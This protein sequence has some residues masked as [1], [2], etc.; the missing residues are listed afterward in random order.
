MN[1]LREV[2]QFALDALHC[3][4]DSELMDRV[5]Q[6]LRAALAEPANIGCLG[7][8]VNVPVTAPQPA[9]P[10]GYKLVPVEPT[11]E[12]MNR[13]RGHLANRDLYAVWKTMAHTAPEAPQPAKRE[14]L[15]DEEIR[16]LWRDTPFKG[17]GGQHDWFMHGFRLAERYYGIG[18]QE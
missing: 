10:P 15:T 4:G 7:M 5:E 13:A 16:H 18:G 11:P 8:P 3:P 12:M 14:P 17:N 6:K 9:I 2:A 1:T